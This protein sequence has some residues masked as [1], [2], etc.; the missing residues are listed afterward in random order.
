[1]AYD[2]VAESIKQL[3]AR[4][5]QHRYVTFDEVNA[6]LPA[7]QVSSEQIEDAMSMLS[8]LGIDVVEASAVPRP[9][10]GETDHAELTRKI[11]ARYPKI[12][13]ALAK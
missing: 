12:L 4:A 8:E 9:V 1:M 11:I 7:D 2:A 10:K 13:A 3:V 6:A 5:K